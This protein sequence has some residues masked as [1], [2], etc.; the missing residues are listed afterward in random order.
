MHTGRIKSQ[1]RIHCFDIATRA[2]EELGIVDSGTGV[3]QEQILH[4]CGHI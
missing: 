1:T 2:A 3:P 4:Q